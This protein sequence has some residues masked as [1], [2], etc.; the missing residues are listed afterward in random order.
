MDD[1]TD[2]PEVEEDDFSEYGRGSSDMYDSPVMDSSGPGAP[3][4]DS[5]YFQ[6]QTNLYTV[7]YASNFAMMLVERGFSRKFTLALYDVVAG[8]FD[9]TQVLA[10]LV[11]TEVSEL[12]MELAVLEAMASADVVLDRNNPFLPE[13]LTIAKT[14]YKHYISRA[15]GTKGPTERERQGRYTLYSEQKMV[16]AVDNGNEQR[17]GLRWIR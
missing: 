12:Y 14:L 13:I 16:N 7:D 6:H 4:L 8:H 17:K 10:S 1:Y 2:T 11:D 9:K 3:P 15:D 5:D